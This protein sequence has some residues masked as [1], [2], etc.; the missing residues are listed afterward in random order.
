MISEKW[1]DDGIKNKFGWIMDKILMNKWCTD[2][3]EFRLVYCVVDDQ[4]TIDI[5]WIC[6]PWCSR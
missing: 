4:F 2:C 3:N 6:D 1:F 5:I